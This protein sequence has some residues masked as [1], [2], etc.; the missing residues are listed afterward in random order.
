MNTVSHPLE[1]A[2]CWAN[3]KYH[4]GLCFC[5][6]VGDMTDATYV[7]NAGTSDNQ[8]QESARAG[9]TLR[10]REGRKRGSPV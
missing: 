4:N 5:D 1:T 6:L 8:A 7:Y 9:G 10:H 2:T 3:M